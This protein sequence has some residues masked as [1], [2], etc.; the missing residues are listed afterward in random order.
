MKKPYIYDYE[1]ALVW[2]SAGDIYVLYE[3]YIH[4][5]FLTISCGIP[6]H[7]DSALL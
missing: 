4:I 2:A 6:A 3:M 7:P 5:Y 1:K